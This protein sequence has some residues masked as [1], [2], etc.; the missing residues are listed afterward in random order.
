MFVREVRDDVIIGDDGKEFRKTGIASLTIKSAPTSQITY[1]IDKQDLEIGHAIFVEYADGREAI[2]T[3][4]E[5]TAEHIIADD[6][7]KWP[8]TGITAL[9]IRDKRGGTVSYVGGSILKILDVLA[10][11]STGAAPSYCS[12]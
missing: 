9:R 10:C 7:G 8:R 1:E 3:V 4:A 11:V 5:M 6:G 12:R 2:I